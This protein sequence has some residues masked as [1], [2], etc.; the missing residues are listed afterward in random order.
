MKRGLKVMLKGAKKGYKK[1]ANSKFVANQRASNK[2]SGNNF[3]FSG[4][5]D[6]DYGFST[7]LGMD[8][9]TIQRKR[10][11]QSYNNPFATQL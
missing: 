8:R 11:K 1:L 10:K 2:S 7:D 3:D 5:G 9:S 6:S 4:L